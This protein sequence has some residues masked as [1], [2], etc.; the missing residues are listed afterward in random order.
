MSPILAKLQPAAPASRQEI[1]Q[2]HARSGPAPLRLARRLGWTRKRGLICLAALAAVGTAIILA[3]NSA[4]TPGPTG[5]AAPTQ[6]ISAGTVAM[7]TI[8]RTLLVTGSLAPWD[9]L[10][11]GA[12]AGGL[13]ITEVNVEQGDRVV[14]GQLLARLD[15]SVLRAQLAQAESA[16]G[17]AEAGLVKSQAMAA[18]ASSDVRRAHA[19]IGNGY[20]SGQIAEQRETAL[21]T[22]VADVNV[23]RQT[24]AT[25]RA[26]RD[27]RAAQLR[28]TEIRAP[29]DG[30][31][32]RRS[33]TLGNVVSVGQELFRLIRDGRVELRAD[34]PE[35]DFAR[36][37][38]GQSAI[39]TLEGESRRRF[40][41]KIRLIAATVDPQTRIGTVYIA[42]PDDP[43]LKPGMYV[44]GV[45]SIGE[46]R[47]LLVPEKALVFKDAKPAI[48]VIG[49]DDRIKLRQVETGARQAGD[50]EILSGVAEGDRIALAGSGYL[51]DNDLVRVEDALPT[52]GVGG[53]AR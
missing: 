23:A 9:E 27:E 30:I 6:T 18:T 24:L 21:A 32:A 7:G 17:Q 26:V 11:I 16:I 38:I 31:V 8:E 44:Q 49:D 15:D 3:R 33:A 47:G 39:I 20:I 42:L 2:P 1:Q 48:F 36:L 51:K 4:P 19:L 34:V 25:A 29:S 13:A 50:V 37:A 5:A 40:E 43:A 35:I 10:P 28:Q 14:K 53:V 52:S 45:V 41:G 22:A 12:E 46:S